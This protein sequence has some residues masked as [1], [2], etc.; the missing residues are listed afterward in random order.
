[1]LYCFRPKSQVDKTHGDSEGESSPVDQAD[2]RLNLDGLRESDEET[3]TGSDSARSDTSKTITPAS[4][5]QRS[6]KDLVHD[7]ENVEQMEQE[8]LDEEDH[9]MDEEAPDGHPKR[10]D[11]PWLSPTGSACSS[12]RPEEKADPRPS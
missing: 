11:T 9:E 1:M 5:G 4:D 12:P 8:N 7:M 10:K 6:D 2:L 3:L